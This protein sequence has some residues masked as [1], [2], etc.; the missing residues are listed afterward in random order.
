MKRIYNKKEEGIA[1]TVGTIFALMIFTALLSMFVTQFVPVTMKS[2]E[3]Q[4]D[5]YVL[6]QFSQLRSTMDIL[7]LTKN[8]N[9]T[10][11]V[12]IKLGADGIPLFASPTYGQLSLY[13]S[14]ISSNYL[15]SLKFSD[16]YGNNITR[17]ASGSIQFISP[18]K[19][20]I[21]EIFNYENG[22]VL[23]Y[24]YQSKNAIF[25]IYPNMKISNVS[26]N[27]SIA[28]TLQSIFGNPNSVTGT[29][30]RAL[31]ISLQGEGDEKYELGGGNLT[32]TI[33]D[34]YN[35]G[36]LDLNFTSYWISYIT[37]VLNSTNAN[38]TVSGDN[39][40]IYHVGDVS[41]KMVYI[42]VE[43]QR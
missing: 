3:A 10:A 26:G 32:I 21:P 11:Y 38:Y 35:F 18:N 12:P 34:D 22:A 30:T 31:A 40:N 24:N 13:P 15:M 41:L 33:N 16:E 4:H 23:R 19:Y 8:T 5:L 27:L 17:N 6:S 39:I 42:E 36:H 1:S 7:T 20:Y 28:V 9:Y 2:N 25:S 14:Q 37:D 29:E 43:I